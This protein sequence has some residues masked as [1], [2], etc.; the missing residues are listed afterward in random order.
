MAKTKSE[1]GYR[2]REAG[3]KLS[4]Q[5]AMVYIMVITSAADRDMGDEELARIGAIVRTLP[6]FDGFD[7]AGTLRVAQACQK[8]L[9]AE[10]GLPDVL[11][12]IRDA[13]TPRLRETAYALAVD[14]AAIDLDIR[15]EED[16]ILDI[17][18]ARFSIDPLAAAAIE[19]AAAIRHRVED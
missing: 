11:E 18:K 15:E 8:A 12:A 19:R 14:V 17:V 4:P 7:Q 13:L 16:R 9:A 5:E 10:G 1:E 3:P 6:L 2:V